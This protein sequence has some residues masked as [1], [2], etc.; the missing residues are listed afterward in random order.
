M[1]IDDDILL[2]SR[3][4]IALG[5]WVPHIPMVVLGSSNVAEAEADV[6]AC[7]RDSVPVLKRYGGGGTV[8]LHDGCVVASVGAWVRQ[9]F[10]NKFYFERLNQAVIDAFSTLWPELGALTQRGLS[11][12]T[13]GDRKVAGTSLFRS[14]NYLLYQA[15]I[16]VDPRIDLLELYLRHPTREPEYRL[17][18]AHRSFVV[19]LG[20]LVPGLSAE[21]AL[22]ALNANLEAALHRHLGDELIPSQPDQVPGLIK[23]AQSHAGPRP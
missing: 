18:R 8:V 15:S 19:G 20:E 7:E 21:A 1:W 9:H 4:P 22:M 12:I 23:R 16:L 10:Q 5:L 14:R 6:A 17:G 11:D 3:E 2:K 13:A